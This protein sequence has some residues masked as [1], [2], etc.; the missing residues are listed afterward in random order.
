MT[1][2]CFYRSLFFFITFKIPEK[3]YFRMYQ[4]YRPG[5]VPVVSR[6]K[7]CLLFFLTVNYVQKQTTDHFRRLHSSQER[8]DDLN[9]LNAR[10]FSPISILQNSQ[11]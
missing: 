11:D 10:H 2:F 5:I 7:T 1:T 3:I 6:L 9:L 8:V 4:N